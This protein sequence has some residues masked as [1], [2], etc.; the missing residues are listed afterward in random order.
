MTFETSSPT[1]VFLLEAVAASGFAPAREL[2]F[3]LC[4]SHPV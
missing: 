1:D 2:G 4:F 3:K